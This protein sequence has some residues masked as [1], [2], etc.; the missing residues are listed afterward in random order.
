VSNESNL[1]DERMKKRVTK[2]GPT[3]TTADN[4]GNDHTNPAVQDGI[5]FGSWLLQKISNNWS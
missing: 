4:D 2:T 1:D 3:K 5:G